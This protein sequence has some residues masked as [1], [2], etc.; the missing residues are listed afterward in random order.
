MPPNPVGRFYLCPGMGAMKRL[1]VLVSVSILMLSMVLAPPVAAAPAP[2]A[3]P[4]ATDGRL[5]G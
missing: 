1:T 4:R 3:A 5:H 2:P